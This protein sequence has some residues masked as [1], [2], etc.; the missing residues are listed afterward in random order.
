MEISL[1]DALAIELDYRKK[2]NSLYS[3]RSFARDLGVSAAYLSN[4]LSHKS[5][6]NPKMIRKICTGLGLNDQQTLEYI[7]DEHRRTSNIMSTAPR[8]SSDQQLRPVELLLIDYLVFLGSDASS[9][10]LADEMGTSSIVVETILEEVIKKTDKIEAV[11]GREL[12]YQLVDCESPLLL[13]SFNNNEKAKE[14]F[15]A[16]YR[17]LIGFI[18]NNENFLETS[19]NSNFNI[20]LS[21]KDLHYLHRDILAFTSKIIDRYSKPSPETQNYYFTMGLNPYSYTLI[22][23][24]V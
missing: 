6:Y 21:E 4:F 12:R 10:E 11:E 22:E 2:C 16:N 14:Y 17:D 8:F 23:N 7:E 19:S 9:R 24:N 18:Q 1:A 15:M 20:H 13:V 3:L 5:A